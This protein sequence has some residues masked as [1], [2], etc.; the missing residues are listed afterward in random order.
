VAKHF[1]EDHTSVECNIFVL[2]TTKGG[3][4]NFT[5]PGDVFNRWPASTDLSPEEIVEDLHDIFP[6]LEI[7]ARD[8]DDE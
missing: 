3:K 5:F 1:A 2:V 8:V 7:E 4:Q 6:C